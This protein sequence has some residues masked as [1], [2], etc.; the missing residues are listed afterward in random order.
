[1]LDREGP[2]SVVGLEDTSLNK[3]IYENLWY[4]YVLCLIDRTI[5]IHNANV[6]HAHIEQNIHII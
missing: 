4:I 5:D 6:L 1:M 3:T 2:L